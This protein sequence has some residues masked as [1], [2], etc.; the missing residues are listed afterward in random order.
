MRNNYIKVLCFLLSF[1]SCLFGV[2]YGLKGQLSNSLIID[3]FK[4]DMTILGIRYIPEISCQQAVSENYFLDAEISMNIYGRTVLDFENPTKEIKPYRVWARFSTDQF[5]VRGG[6]QKI[7]FGPATLL[8]P[9]MWF[10]QIDPRDP[11]QIT[12][13]VYGLLAR[14]YFLNNTNI[15]AWVLYGQDERKGLEIIP[16]Q[17]GSPEFGGRLQFPL[18]N[19]ELAATF[20]RRKMNIEKSIF[21][22]TDYQ[23]KKHENRY[24]I[25][26]KWDLGVGLWFEAV[27]LRN[28][29]VQQELEQQKLLNLGIDYT[30]AIGNGIHVLGEYFYYEFSQDKS[31]VGALFIDYNLSMFD[32]LMGIV[33]WDKEN[34]NFYRYAT[35]RRTYDKWSINVNFFWNPPTNS[36]FNFADS[37]IERQLSGKGLLFMLIYNH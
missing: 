34:S 6:L 24:A 10:D 29:I 26:G 2:D 35:W 37:N 36:L 30:F 5:E 3:E 13:G 22:L 15:W 16:S 27:L 17:K 1:N 7:N 18:F 14:Y 4:S 8:R 31:K 19:G 25:D 12:N 33:Y 20:H 23:E 28:D 9:L 21:G 32:Q 11:L